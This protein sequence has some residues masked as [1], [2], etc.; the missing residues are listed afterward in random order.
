MMRPKAH[1][2]AGFRFNFQNKNLSSLSL[3]AS[4]SDNQVF[5]YSFSAIKKAEVFLTRII[6]T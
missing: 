5:R 6:T 3:Y 2:L 4:M 1:F